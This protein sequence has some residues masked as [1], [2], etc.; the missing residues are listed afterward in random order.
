MGS[1]V[2]SGSALSIVSPRLRRFFGATEDSEGESLVSAVP[3]ISAFWVRDFLRLA[4]VRFSDPLSTVTSS[5]F[6]PTVDDTEGI[7]GAGGVGEEWDTV[8]RTP[9]DRDGSTTGVT[10][11]VRDGI[12]GTEGLRGLLLD[13]PDAD[14]TLSVGAIE[15]VRSGMPAGGG[16]EVLGWADGLVRTS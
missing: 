4:L 16:M 11:F 2:P 7:G 13:E 3:S 9:R 6:S 5:A 12:I 15:L 8:I 1:G 14:D 10:V